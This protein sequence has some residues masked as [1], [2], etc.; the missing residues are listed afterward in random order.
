MCVICTCRFIIL[1]KRAFNRQGGETKSLKFWKPA[2][3]FL[4][5]TYLSSWIRNRLSSLILSPLDLPSFSTSRLLVNPKP[6][7]P[8]FSLARARV[9]FS[10]KLPL[11]WNWRF[12]LTFFDFFG[13][14]VSLGVSFQQV[15]NHGF[16][17]WETFPLNPH[18]RWGIHDHLQE[19]YQQDFLADRSKLF[20]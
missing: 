15:V 5:F 6:S 7:P 18:S 11:P 8:P 9:L 13:T 14:G 16:A 12:V 4:H 3:F 20:F 10:S 1:I 17:D 19:P 2:S